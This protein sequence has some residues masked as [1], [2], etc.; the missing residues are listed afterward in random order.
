[1]EA[2]VTDNMGA[3]QGWGGGG[4]GLGPYLA[5]LKGGEGEVATATRGGA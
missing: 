2:G 4:Q 5:R 1:M 3:C